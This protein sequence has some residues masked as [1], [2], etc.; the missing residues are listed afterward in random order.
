MITIGYMHN[1]AIDQNILFNIDNKK[2]K[3]FNKVTF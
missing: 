3:I 2:I 1:K